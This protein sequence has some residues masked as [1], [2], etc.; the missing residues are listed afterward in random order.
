MLDEDQ[1]LEIANDGDRSIFQTLKVLL[2]FPVSYLCE[3]GFFSAVTATRMRLESRLKI[4]NTMLVSLSPIT[5]RCDRR[6]A[7]KEAQAAY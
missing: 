7:S 3:V 5:P 4:R 6:V 2:L 1:L